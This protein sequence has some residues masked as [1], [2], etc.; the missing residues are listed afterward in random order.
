MSTQVEIREED[1]FKQALADVRSDESPTNWVLA[2]HW[3]GNPNVI[4]CKAKGSGGANEMAGALQDSEAMYGLVRLVELVDSYVESTVKF[5]YVHWI[6]ES[7]PFIKKGKFGV[8]HGSVEEH[9][10]PSHCVIET[11]HREDLTEEEMMKVISETSGRTNKVLDVTDAA[12]RPDRGFTSSSN[13]IKTGR[14]QSSFQTPGAVAVNID[15]AVTQ[16]IAE[17]RS[18]E[19]QIDW[20]VGSYAENNA[21]KP[22]VLTGKG[23]DG[24]KGMVDLLKNDVVAYAFLRVQDEVDGISTVKFVFIQWVGENV[25]PMTKGKISTHK[26]TVEKAFH[27]AH[28]TIYATVLGELSEDLILSKVQSASG[29]KS[30]V[31]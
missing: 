6:G 15:D 14:T 31:K 3:E 21:K 9:F 28:V 23:T 17:V 18:D 10:Q 16:A 30:H 26:S 4:Y 13:V 7:V 24:L 8:V 1:S 27:P 5:V 12:Q 11:A 29:S 2:A 25:K 19:T 22:I 20:C